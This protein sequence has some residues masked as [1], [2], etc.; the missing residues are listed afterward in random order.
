[1][2]QRQHTPAPGQKVTIYTADGKICRGELTVKE[3]I[4]NEVYFREPLTWVQ[5]GD[6]MYW[7]ENKKKKPTF[8]QHMGRERLGK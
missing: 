1:M 2:K 3:V 8:E 6:L 7:F 5:V 4:G